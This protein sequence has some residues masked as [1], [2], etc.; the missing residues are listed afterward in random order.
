M[1]HKQ[2]RGQKM[3][4]LRSITLT[5]AETTGRGRAPGKRAASLPH[6]SIAAKRLWLG[7]RRGDERRREKTRGDERRREETRG[8]ENGQEGMRR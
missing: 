1:R 4:A 2:V 6:R 5:G 8:D 7:E 3:N